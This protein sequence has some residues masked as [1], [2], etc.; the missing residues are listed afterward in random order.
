[1]NVDWENLRH[2]QALVTEGT[3][4][5]A[6]RA[7]GVEHATVSRRI[8]ALEDEL[9]SRLVDRRGHRVVATEVGRRVAAH[10]ERMRMEAEALI[11]AADGSRDRIV[12]CVIV[13][14]P[15]ILAASRLAGP[16]ADLGRGHPGLDIRLVGETREASLERREADIAVRMR[17]PTKGDLNV[18]KVGEVAFRLYAHPRFLATVPRDEWV[19][20]GFDGETERSP[21]G[22]TLRRAANGREIVLRAGSSEIQK[23]A[24]LAGAGI[25][26]LPD[27]M[28][29]D[30]PVL[31]RVDSDEPRLIRQVHIVVHRD[32]RDAAH[33]RVVVDRL[34]AALAVRPGDR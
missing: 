5:A 3:L 30:D 12:G 14:A 15:P 11:L 20:L 31:V 29:E 6:A 7:L 26:L 13:S 34:R 10:T 28:A 23:A 33:I 25:A 18:L 22:A 32:L 16:L 1:M 19:F 8:A 21:L 27:F 9:G 24:A 4:S 17:L 2:F